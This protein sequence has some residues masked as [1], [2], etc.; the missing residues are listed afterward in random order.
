MPRAG[1]VLFDSATKDQL[2]NIFL[3]E[4][5]ENL[6]T[7]VPYCLSY[8]LGEVMDH[9]EMLNMVLRSCKP[10]LGWPWACKGTGIG[11]WA[12]GSPPWQESCSVVVMCSGPLSG[13]HQ[14]LRRVHDRD[15]CFSCNMGKQ[16]YQ[17]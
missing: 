9:W 4:N 15:E 17:L 5:K 7:S 16:L 2:C 11:P 1:W 8:T 3:G 6:I 10:F 12:S 14:T 13:N